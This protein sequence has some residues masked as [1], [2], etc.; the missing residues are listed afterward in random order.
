MPMTKEK[1]VKSKKNLNHK[2]ISVVDFKK[3]LNKIYSSR[4]RESKYQS[5]LDE[6]SEK[7]D[8]QHNLIT[9]FSNF[10]SWLIKAIIVVYLIGLGLNIFYGN[11]FDLGRLELIVYTFITI[12]LGVLLDRTFPKN[13]E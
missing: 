6:E 13:K 9:G 3:N 2:P 11:T 12:S 4:L 5:N 1:I 7:K 10:F 8:L